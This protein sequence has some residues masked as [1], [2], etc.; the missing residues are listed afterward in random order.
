MDDAPITE[1]QA[2]ITHVRGTGIANLR[3]TLKVALYGG[4]WELLLERLSPP[5]RALL[6]HAPPIEEWIDTALLLEIHLA[7]QSLPHPDTRRVRG[8][9]TAEEEMKRL[10]LVPSQPGADPRALILRFPSMWP[11]TNQGGWVTID[12]LRDG[13]G[14]LSAWAIFPYPD[15]LRDVAPAWICQA[16]SMAGAKNP[17]VDY[18][19]PQAEDVAYRHRYW[20]K[21]T[22]VG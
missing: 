21:W 4:R 19:G 5:A 1:A 10:N 18:L 16:L 13:E 15:Y 11:E 20:M 17:K 6:E 22:P 3:S 7:Q 12:S 2:H 14:E 8:E 9:L